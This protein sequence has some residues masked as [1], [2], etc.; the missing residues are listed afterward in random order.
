MNKP[1]PIDTI[2]ETVK[3]SKLNT[4]KNGCVIVGT[5]YA[6]MFH[7][8]SLSGPIYIVQNAE[9]KIREHPTTLPKDGAILSKPIPHN[10]D[11]AA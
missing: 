2:M 1:K 3:T 9:I 8:V 6:E 4:T 10:C 11:R 7:S 5:Q